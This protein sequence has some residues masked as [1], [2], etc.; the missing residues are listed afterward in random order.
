VEAEGEPV[1]KPVAVEDGK[2]D[3]IWNYFY[4]R[5]HQL[6][7]FFLMQPK[8]S[9]RYKV[10]SCYSLSLS[11][12]LNNVCN[13][14][15]LKLLQ[16]Q[17]FEFGMNINLAI[18]VTVNYFLLHWQLQFFIDLSYIDPGEALCWHSLDN[19]IPF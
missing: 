1:A 16:R 9:V 11:L 12:S 13:W 18:C 19:Y 4:V 7:R 3:W 15:F 8:V 10:F 2:Q 17:K 6:L 5:E 14:D